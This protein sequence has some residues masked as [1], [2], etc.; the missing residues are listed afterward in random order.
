MKLTDRIRNFFYAVTHA[1]E[2]VNIQMPLNEESDKPK[3]EISQNAGTGI[4]RNVEELTSDELQELKMSLYNEMPQEEAAAYFDY[5]EIPDSVVKEHYAGV[6]FVHDD[7]SCN[8]PEAIEEEEPY[9]PP[10]RYPAQ[11]LPAG[12]EWVKYNDG[13]GH[14]EGPEGQQFFHY[15]LSPYASSNGVEFK[16]TAS[17]RWSV[18]W[19]TPDK[20][21]WTHA[22]ERVRDQYLPTQE[23]AA[24][25]DLAPETA[26]EMEM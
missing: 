10:A 20:D 19:N 23:Q 15:D 21:F 8:M 24:A 4:Y 26:Y 12:W 13:S 14:L 9:T 1:D 3:Q 2:V 6:A 11:A 7:F 17:D 18:F 22:E 25:C 16:E 5:S